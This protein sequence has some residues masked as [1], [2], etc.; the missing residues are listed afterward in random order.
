MIF[1]SCYHPL[2]GI[3]K[4]VDPKSGKMQY[5]IK[6][7]P[8]N[9]TG[10][11]HM[12]GI[13]TIPCGKCTGCRLDYSRQW[14]NRCMLELLYHKESWFLTL[15][16]DDDHVPKTAYAINDD[17]EAAPALTLKPRDL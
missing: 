14:A 3:P 1:L 10:D 9:W 17:G 16:Y 11:E 5:L 7:F 8:K 4:G 6:P 13:V 15:T 12:D 2:M